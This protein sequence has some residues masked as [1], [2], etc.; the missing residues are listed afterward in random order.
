MKLLRDMC[1]MFIRER[2][3]LDVH[4]RVKS[5]GVA[6]PTSISVNNCCGN[7]SPVFPNDSI[8]LAEGDVV[9]IDIGV[10]I[11][12]YISTV[13]HTTVVGTFENAITGKVA[14]VIC[15]AYFAS[16]CAIRL[17]RPG[18]S[19]TDVTN[20][21]QRVA[22]IFDVRPLQGV[23][24]HDLSKNVIDGKRV[25]INKAEVDQTVEEF[26][27]EVNQVYSIDIV[28]STGEG[29][30]RQTESK[31]TIYRRSDVNY[32]LKSRSARN[33]VNQIKTKYSTRPFN[34]RSFEARNR[35]GIHELVNHNLVHSYPVLYEKNGEIVA[36][37]KFTV[38]I[39]RSSTQRLNEGFPLPWVT[40]EFKIETDP[41]LSQKMAMST[42][43]NKKKKKEKNQIKITNKRIINKII[44]IIKLN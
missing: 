43:R 4:S 19:N 28:M 40:S 29:K 37:F 2:Y 38:L 26:N 32:S 9:K 20:A 13:A 8:S 33:L 11:D 39:L 21:I 18:K 35:V 22:N 23:L 16:E 24:S 5:K 25:I 30:S 44:K 1:W 10:H 41:E 34:I 36:Q 31:V 3:V 12:G 6:F 27:F 15:A 42:K 17:I 14:D 7:Y